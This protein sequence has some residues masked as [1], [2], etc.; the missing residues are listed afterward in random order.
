LLHAIHVRQE[1]AALAL[2]DGGA[3]VNFS[4]HSGLTPLIMAAGYG[5]SELALGLLEKGA[6]PYAEA[7]DGTNAL[8]AAAGGGT[9][10]NLLFGPKL[11]TCFPDTVR[12]LR[13]AAPG[14]R[15]RADLSTA[16]VAWLARSDECSRIVNQL[17]S[18]SKSPTKNPKKADPKKADPG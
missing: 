15:L 14:L 5:Q 13:E 6:D 4:S 12:I 8:W 10:R 7:D 9:I 18:D 2:V 11:G 1:E 17:R 16:T 3:D